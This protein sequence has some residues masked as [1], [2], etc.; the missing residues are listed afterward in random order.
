VNEADQWRFRAALLSL[1]N[2][3]SRAQLLDLLRSDYQL[4][5]EDNRLLADFLEYLLTKPER[6][7]LVKLAKFGG[8]LATKRGKPVEVFSETWVVS[9]AAAEARR[10]RDWA[11]KRYPENK[12]T[13]ATATDFICE[14]RVYWW[15]KAQGKLKPV[16]AEGRE[17]ALHELRSKVL[18]KLERSQKPEPK[19]RRPRRR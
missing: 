13:L 1:G 6:R 10:F 12:I 15:L 9:D 7:L 2:A 4:T 8:Q 18:A 14:D 3:K 19:R 5:I 16:D 17:I 11:A